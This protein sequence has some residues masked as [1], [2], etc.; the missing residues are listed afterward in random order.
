MNEAFLFGVT[1]FR[2]VV[3]AF[4]KAGWARRAR[5]VQVSLGRGP[6]SDSW[7]VLQEIKTWKLLD[8]EELSKA[9]IQVLYNGFAGDWFTT[10][11]FGRSLSFRRRSGDNWIPSLT[12]MLMLTALAASS[13]FI[14][15]LVRK[16]QKRKRTITYSPLEGASSVESNDVSGTR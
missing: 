5:V 12:L 4:R 3:C 1:K 6:T 7:K 13:F 2:V 16:F 14:N 8:D 10:P 9:D 11:N 15:Y